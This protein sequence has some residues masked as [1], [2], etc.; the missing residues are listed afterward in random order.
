MVRLL[1]GTSVKWL[2]ARGFLAWGLVSWAGPVLADE[3]EES[4]QLR[5]S[6]LCH[7]KACENYEFF[8]FSVDSTRYGYSH[9]TCP[10]DLVKGR[11]RFTYHLREIRP[12]KRKRKSTGLVLEGVRYPGYFKSNDYWVEEL[13]AQKAGKNSYTFENDRGLKIGIELVTEKQVA[14]YLRVS[15]VEGERF[16]YRGEFEEIYFGLR[17]RVYLSPDGERAAVVLLL[18]AMIK[19]DAALVIFSLNP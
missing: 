4:A 11:A 9:L 6:E 1:E 2:V 19:V 8:G 12:G 16:T 5:C 15:G 17:P 14:W 10:G 18:D 7:D 3:V 13:P